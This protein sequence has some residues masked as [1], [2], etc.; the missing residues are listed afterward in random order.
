MELSASRPIDA[1]A[2]IFAP[3][4]RSGCALCSLSSRLAGCSFSLML[5]L[6]YFGLPD[7]TLSIRPCRLCDRVRGSGIP[8]CNHASTFSLLRPVT[9][10]DGR[11][12][13]LSS[14]NVFC[15][16]YNAESWS[17]FAAKW[18]LPFVFIKWRLYSSHRQKVAGHSKSSL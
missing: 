18:L 11:L 8:P 16:G 5:A 10:A 3:S 4:Q 13:I 15:H 7:S 17:M 6:C 12:L 14:C 9:R 1:L 2:E